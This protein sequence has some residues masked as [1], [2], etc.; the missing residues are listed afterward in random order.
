[1]NCKNC[2]ESLD[3]GWKVCPACT[4]PVE[5]IIHCSACGEK[6]KDHWVKCPICQ[7]SIVQ[8]FDEHI[9]SWKDNYSSITIGNQ[10]WMLPNLNVSRFR[11]GDLIQEAI[12]DEDWKRLGEE[13]KPAWCH[14]DNDL[15]KGEVFGKLYNWYAVNDPRGL[16]PKGWHIPTD[17]EWTIFT[18]ETVSGIS[19]EMIFVEGGK[20]KMGADDDLYKDLYLDEHPSH[21][22]ELNGY[23]LAKLPVTQEIFM[24]V[25]GN[26]PSVLKGEQFPVTNVSM[27]RA[28]QFLMKLNQMTGKNYRLP[29]EAEWEYAARGGQLS[30]KFKYSGSN[31]VDDV[32]WYNNNSSQTLQTV[33]RKN[34]NE[35]GIYDLSGN[36]MERCSDIYHSNY[37]YESP[38][39]NPQGP[40]YISTL[41]VIRGGCFYSIAEDC[42]VSRRYSESDRGCDYVGLRLAH[43]MD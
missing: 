11:N 32:A 29:T 7:K 30:K 25:M 40:Q 36:V 18:V 31:N 10:I 39:F 28:R 14:Y 15:N 17:E 41:Y 21:Q 1:M 20:Y 22:V 26:N 24:A 5:Q 3:P 6:I 13:G 43:S 9:D 37:Y 27:N 38:V 34:P 12:F 23:H 33:G 35:L 8:E 2:N 16:A 4:K 42:Q 19:F